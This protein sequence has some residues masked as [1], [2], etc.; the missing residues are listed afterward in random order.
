[1]RKLGLSLVG[2]N[3]QK[4]MQKELNHFPFSNLDAYISEGYAWATKEYHLISKMPEISGLDTDVISFAFVNIYNHFLH[5]SMNY[6]EGDVE[7]WLCDF[8]GKES[9]SNKWNMMWESQTIITTALYNY[10]EKDER[11]IYDSL[12]SS[13]NYEGED[14]DGDKIILNPIEGVAEYK[15]MDFVME[16]LRW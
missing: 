13:I 4:L 1:M 11:K 7:D 8:Y 16:G 10:Y 12:V 3:K 6:R 5:I 2:F 15:V 14:F 9:L